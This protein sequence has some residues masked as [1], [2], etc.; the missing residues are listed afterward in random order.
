MLV[1]SLW[2]N[3]KQMVLHQFNRPR[4]DFATYTLVTQSI[5]P[6]RVCLNRT[7]RNPRDSCAKFLQ[8]E[9]LLIMPACMA[10][11]AQT[12][13]QWLIQHRQWA[14]ALR[15]WSTEVPFV[16]IVQASHPG[17]PPSRPDWWASVVWQHTLSFYAIQEL[18]PEDNRAP[19]STPAALGP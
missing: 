10:R 18:L 12:P 9:Q 3:V 8:G 1:E 4:L 2:R 7:V 11:S 6:Y 16:S 17:P 14:L 5:A 19:A 15:L 13:D